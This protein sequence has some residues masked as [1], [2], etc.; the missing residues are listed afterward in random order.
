MWGI[1]GCDRAAS[2]RIWQCGGIAWNCADGRTCEFVKKV[3]EGSVSDLWQWRRRGEGCT[4]GNSN[5]KG[6][7]DYDKSDQ[8]APAQRSGWIYQGFGSRGV[9]GSYRSCR[10][11]LYVWDT[12]FR[13][14][15]RHERSGEQ[16][17]LLSWSGKETMLLHRKNRAWYLHSGSRG[18]IYAANAG[19]TAACR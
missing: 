17:S 5:L 16:V 3:H 1:Y 2:G 19:F 18:K 11:Q 9:S 12:H 10:E 15:V 4:P 13:A 7:R 14:A 8:Y 6:S